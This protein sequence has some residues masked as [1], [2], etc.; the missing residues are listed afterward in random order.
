MGKNLDDL[1]WGTAQRLEF[2]EFRLFWEG[3]LNRSDLMKR[4]NVS[5]PQASADIARYQELAPDNI[6]Y[7]SSDKVFKTTN[8]FKPVFYTPNADR[9][10]VRLKAFADGVIPH[11]ETGLSV[12]PAL[13]AIPI[14]H[15]RVDPLILRKLLAAIKASSGLNVFYHS[16]NLK[17]PKPLWREIT[18]HSLAFDGLR[19][20]VRGYC[21]LEERF[22]D[23]ILSR[24]LEVGDF[25]E[26]GAAA[27]ADLEWN[28]F[29]DIVLIPN[30]ELSPNQRETIALDYGMDDYRITIRV[31]VALLYYINK[32]LRLDVAEKIDNPK[33]TPV[34]VANRAEFI[35]ALKEAGAFS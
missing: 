31:R 20:H 2:I 12:V 22:K 32:R 17:R 6:N 11:E 9:Y 21:H 14:L 33:E 29:F 26:P 3:R 1:R 18:P 30:P 7:D 13:D 10:L 25:V 34:V 5:M 4:F 19:W 16:M 28:S 35:Q 8:S 23:F 15:R 24:F 27:K